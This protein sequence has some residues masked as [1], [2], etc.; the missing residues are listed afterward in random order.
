VT[1][2]PNDA[3]RQRARELMLGRD[4][5]ADLVSTWVL[6][7]LDAIAQALADA[8]T[9]GRAQGFDEGYAAGSYDA[10]HGVVQ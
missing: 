5:P 3:D 1:L 8:R 7:L 4:D 6:G 9:E 2:Q 10:L